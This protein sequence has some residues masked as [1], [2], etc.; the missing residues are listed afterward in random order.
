M[1]SQKPHGNAFES[2]DNAQSAQNNAGD[3]NPKMFPP[4]DISKPNGEPPESTKS[5]PNHRKP[6]T[7][8]DWKR[9]I[10]VSTLL[11]EFLGLAGLVWYCIVTQYEWNTFDS[12]RQTMEKEFLTGERAWVAPFDMSFI[13][14][15]EQTNWVTCKLLFKNTGKT[16]ALNVTISAALGSAQFVPN[17]NPPPI[18]GPFMLT[19]DGTA[20]VMV[21]PLYMPQFRD[22]IITVACIYGRVSYQDIFRSNHWSDF[23]WL[24]HND[25]SFRPANGHN[26]CDDSQ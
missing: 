6:R 5:K 26:S 13:A 23:C 16:P 24:I 8:E 15:K 14:E 3:T 22:E 25:S 7:W 18:S 2:G 19:P 1:E 21:Q 17:T 11:I 9:M 10:E 4:S 12:E 20:F